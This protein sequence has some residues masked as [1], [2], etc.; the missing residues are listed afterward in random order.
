MGDL[1]PAFRATKRRV[2]HVV[3]APTVFQVTLI[4]NNQYAKMAYS[5]MPC[6]ESHQHTLL[7]T[8]VGISDC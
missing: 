4:Q 2:I 8:A 3:L 5:G 6:P 1:F 7:A